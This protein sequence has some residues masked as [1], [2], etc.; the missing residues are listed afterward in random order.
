M[1]SAA[2]QRIAAIRRFNRFYTRKIGALG[3]HLDSPYSLTEVR[4]LYE[5]AHSPSSSASEIASQLSLDAGYLSR[6][7]RRFGE[8]GL[9][10]RVPSP[11]DRRQSALLLSETG[12]EVFATLDART[13]AEIGT[14]L[15][16]LTARDQAALVESLERVEALLDPPATA[17]GDVIL[18]QHRT[19]D[20]GWVIHRHGAWY[21]SEFGWTGEFEALVAE[22]CAQ[23]IRS[24]DP[25]RERCWIAERDDLILG[26]VFLVRETDDVAR[27]RLLLV[28]PEARGLGLG[29]RLV[30]ECTT[31]AREAG[32]R[33]ITLWTNSVLH[34]ARRSYERAGYRLVREERHH[35]FGHDLV[36]QHWEL[37]L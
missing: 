30:D 26:S 32:Y 20:M 21:A 36:G 28:E 35:S 13:D 25:D 1:P 8:Q 24:F 27:L 16:E 12:R 18:R 11:A 9:V 2:E 19:G 4:V 5:L 7:L 14:A 31:F 29:A 37:D 15:R 22:I 23:F 33:R 3:R 10:K 6:I 17:R 34:A